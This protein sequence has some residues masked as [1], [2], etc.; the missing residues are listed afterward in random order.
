VLCD[1][2]AVASALVGSCG[3]DLQ[4]LP[5]PAGH[6]MQDSGSLGSP[7]PPVMIQYGLVWR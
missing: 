1:G 6:R 3:R 7:L 2:K 4:K 5:H